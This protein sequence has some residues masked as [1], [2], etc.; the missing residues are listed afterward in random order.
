[1]PDY[2]IT[3]ADSHQLS[4]NKDLSILPVV[5]RG[6]QLVSWSYNANDEAAMKKELEFVGRVRNNM[7]LVLRKLATEKDSIPTYERVG[8]TEFANVRA[9]VENEDPNQYVEE[10]FVIL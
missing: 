10:T 8:F 5:G 7:C 2:T 6:V 4:L 9:G 1:L 3:N